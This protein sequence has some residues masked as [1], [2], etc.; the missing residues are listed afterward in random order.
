MI[1]F[2]DVLLGQIIW[3]KLF[4]MNF[5]KIRAYCLL[6]NLTIYVN[7]V[8]GK[9]KLINLSSIYGVLVTLSIIRSLKSGLII[10]KN[11]NS[12]QNFIYY[13]YSYKIKMSKLNI[14]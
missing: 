7:I 2:R 1:T 13:R 6:I 9:S 5:K 14:E 3:L 8:R 10:S 4:M 12:A 11:T